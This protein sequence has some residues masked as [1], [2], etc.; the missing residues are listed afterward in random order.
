LSISIFKKSNE[1]RR[2]PMSVILVGG[3]GVQG[4]P[5]LLIEKLSQKKKNLMRRNIHAFPASSKT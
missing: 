2:L 4:Q 3:L 1:A 5:G